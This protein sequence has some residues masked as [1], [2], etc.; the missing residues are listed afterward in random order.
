MQQVQSRPSGLT[1]RRDVARQLL[2]QAAVALVYLGLAAALATV[3]VFIG[4]YW[5]LVW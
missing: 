2:G 3:A 5:L 4:L 1:Q